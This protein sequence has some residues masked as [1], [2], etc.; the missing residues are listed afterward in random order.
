MIM[1]T[2]AAT[3]LGIAKSLILLKNLHRKVEYM[4]RG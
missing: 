4:K 3:E 2:L 1:R